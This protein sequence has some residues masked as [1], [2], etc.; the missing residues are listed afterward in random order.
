MRDP[1]VSF[2]AEELIQ[3]CNTSLFACRQLF[4]TLT[5]DFE[6]GTMSDE[7]A[8]TQTHMMLRHLDHALMP[9]ELFSNVHP[10]ESCRLGMAELEQQGKKLASEIYMSPELYTRMQQ[11]D[12]SSC[13][14]SVQRFIEKLLID[15]RSVGAHLS[16]DVRKRILELQ[17]DITMLCQQ[18][19][20]NIVAD[21]K[22]ISLC[23]DDL[24]GL[25]ED[26]IASHAPNDAGYV[27]ITTDYPDYFPFMTYGENRTR[28]EELELLFLTRGSEKNKVTLQHLLEKRREMAVLLGYHHWAEYSTND[29]MTKNATV[30][31]DFLQT[32]HGEAKER[33]EEEMRTLKVFAE[34][35]GFVGEL[36]SWD[37]GFFRNLYRKEMFAFDTAAIRRYF[38]Y[39]QVQKG[40]FDL[41]EEL[42]ELRFE[43]R[44]VSTWHE[45]VEAFTVKNKKGE[46]VGYMYLDMFP[47]K[48]KYGHAAQFSLISGVKNEELPEAALVCNFPD[49]K[50]HPEGLSLLGYDEVKTFFHEFGHLIHSMCGG[51][52][53]FVPQSGVRTEWDFV[54]VPSQLFETWA[55]SYEVLSTFAIT[56]DTKEVISAELVSNLKQA[57]EW[58]KGLFATTQVFQANISLQ[59]HLAYTPDTSNDS[60]LKELQKK[61]SVVPFHEGTRFDLC[62]GHLTGYSAIYYTYLWS[63]ALAK[64]MTSI[65]EEKG[66]L[67]KELAHRYRDTILAPGGTKPASTILGDFLGRPYT[68]EAFSR[69]LKA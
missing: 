8:V 55:T 31:S 66:L 68:F 50:K 56:S 64:D 52:A 40:L 39:A 11:V 44:H 29:K 22:S 48:G 18:Y 58:G 38:P 6:K 13:S 41:V 33:A 30:V 2:S 67:N 21:T 3:Q 9:A 36:A 34:K 62:F 32:V 63:L 16:F 45:S 51:Q 35:H 42:F 25:P 60:F 27:E 47:R 59:Y 15:M 69:W 61:Y 14:I 46:S 57:Q 53:E 19:E 54:E 5:S 24:K 12:L 4:A 10:E 7:S 1:F 49:P 26:Y 17:T 37:I 20:R 43:K 65:F 23:A 28:R